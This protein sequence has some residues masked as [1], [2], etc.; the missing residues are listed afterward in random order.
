MREVATSD[1]LIAATAVFVS[2]LV[3]FYVIF[4]AMNLI[5]QLQETIGVGMS[6][7]DKAR[8]M[9]QLQLI[10]PIFF[11]IY[12]IVIGAIL[13]FFILRKK[14]YGSQDLSQEDLYI[15]QMQQRSR[16]LGQQP[17]QY[18]QQK[19]YF[20]KQTGPNSPYRKS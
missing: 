10:P 3:I 19:N 16:N 20:G 14:D 17:R 8:T 11:G 1:L 9:F 2:G 13:Y 5:I 7:T 15:T 4:S 12:V 18:G 6:E